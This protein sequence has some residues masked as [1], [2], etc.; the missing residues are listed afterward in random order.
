M[1]AK[2]TL[3]LLLVLAPAV[4]AQPRPAPTMTT[5]ADGVYLFSSPPYSDVGLDGNAVVIVSTDGVLVFDSNG[6]PA[7]AAMVLA[8]IRKLTAQPVRFLVNSHWHWD[9]WYGSEVYRKA[10]PGLPIIAHRM[11]REMMLGPALAFNQPGIDE[12]LP[13]HIKD[14]ERAAATD[15]SAARRGRLERH[16]AED[17]FFLAEKRG[18]AHLAAN[19]TFTDTLIIHLGD[20]EIQVL[21]YDR[22][23]TPGD[24]YL[25][26]P[27]EKILV[28]G[29]LLINPISFALSAYP[30]GWLRTLE[31]LDRLEVT[32][33][34]PGHGTVL[35]DKQLLEAHIGLFRELLARGKSARDRGLDVDSAKAEILPTLAAL[36]PAFTN[37]NSA[38]DAQFDVYLVDWYLHR[39]YDELAGPLSDAIAP[40]PR[41]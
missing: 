23:V 16:L 35:R 30:T 27:K 26:L 7:A 38:N 29:D 31:A 21:H 33:I 12:Q 32:V 11:T 8:E 2:A 6:T 24:T 4:R 20:R 39:V 41:R 34:I 37:G 14:V 18:S 19:V 15:T 25:Y 3:A 40:V 1:T 5:V 9:H 13:G 22:A 36:R 17:R 28:T 10:F